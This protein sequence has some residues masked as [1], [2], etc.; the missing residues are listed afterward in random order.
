M[1]VSVAYSLPTRYHECVTQ[2]QGGRV[3]FS[4]FGY[5]DVCIDGEQRTK[6]VWM[7][8]VKFPN[9]ELGVEF[10]YL[11]RTIGFAMTAL[12]A[13]RLPAED[14]GG[15]RPRIIPANGFSTTSTR[16]PWL[17]V[18]VGAR[19]AL[20]I[21]R[22]QDYLDAV[23]ETVFLDIAGREVAR[24][25]WTPGGGPG[26][27]AARRAKS[28]LA[29]DP[30]RRRGDLEHARLAARYVEIIG[31]ATDAD[32]ARRNASRRPVPTLADEFG[33][34]EKVISNMI[35]EARNRELLTRPPVRTR[36]GGEL[37]QKALNTLMNHREE[38]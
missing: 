22:Q 23:E 25:P 9:W 7:T 15:E 32:D 24:E 29:V 37:T 13:S 12:T 26:S 17:E 20:R 6:V 30:P 19:R 10:D 21:A 28:R 5:G 14:L 3:T 2:V 4:R 11:G 27:E 34:P 31:W 8:H 1:R 36:A 35:N 16:I 33:Y 38:S 18:E